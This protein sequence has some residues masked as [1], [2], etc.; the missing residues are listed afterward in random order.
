MLINKN[1]SS[2]GTKGRLHPISIA[3][4][5]IADIFG[6]MGFGVVYGPEL[7]NEWHNFAALNIP[8]DH[9]ARDMQDTFGYRISQASSA[10]PHDLG[11]HS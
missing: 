2:V 9:P 4:R 8:P 7:E 5:E 10:H 3:I 6:R 11:N 1:N